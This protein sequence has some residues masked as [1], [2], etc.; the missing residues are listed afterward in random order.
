MPQIVFQSSQLLALFHIHQEANKQ[1][2][3]VLI[4]APIYPKYLG[5]MILQIICMWPLIDF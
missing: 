2:E 3:K 5:Q 4:T 1:I